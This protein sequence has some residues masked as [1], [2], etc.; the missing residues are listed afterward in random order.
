MGAYVFRNRE[1]DGKEDRKVT[2][3]EEKKEEEKRE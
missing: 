2:T 1:G 3:E